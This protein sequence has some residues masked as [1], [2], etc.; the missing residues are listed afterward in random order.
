MFGLATRT[1]KADWSEKEIAAK[2]TRG[3]TI[4]HRPRA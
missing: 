2:P 3:L 4:S 1:E